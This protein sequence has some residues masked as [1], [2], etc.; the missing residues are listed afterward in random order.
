M[1]GMELV[2]QC[3]LQLHGLAA[4]PIQLW[5]GEG[6]HQQ[7]PGVS[8]IPL[9]TGHSTQGEGRKGVSGGRGGIRGKEGEGSVKKLELVLHTPNTYTQTHTHY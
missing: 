1:K 4:A 8:D 3:S 2:V 5:T 9:R 6:G 7:P